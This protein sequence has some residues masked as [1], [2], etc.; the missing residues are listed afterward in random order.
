MK[1]LFKKSYFTFQYNSFYALCIKFHKSFVKYK[2][3][4]LQNSSP[5]IASDII[6]NNHYNNKYY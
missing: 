6:I 2:E 1:F 5:A 3:N 4:I